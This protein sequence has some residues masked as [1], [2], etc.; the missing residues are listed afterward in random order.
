MIINKE[1]LQEKFNKKLTPTRFKVVVSFLN[2]I[3]TDDSSGLVLYSADNFWKPF[4]YG[5]DIKIKR[6]KAK[7]YNDLIINFNKNCDNTKKLIKKT[8]TQFFDTFE[9]NCEAELESE[10]FELSLENKDVVLTKHIV[11]VIKELD[12]IERSFVK[13]GSVCRVIPFQEVL[14]KFENR[15]IENWLKYFLKKG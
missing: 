1:L 2:F 3:L 7:T 8:K 14:L 4:E 5:E 10:I 9:T 12:N 15:E 13:D 6:V 11:C